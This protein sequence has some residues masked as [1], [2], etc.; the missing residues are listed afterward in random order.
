MPF[1]QR[2]YVLITLILLFSFCLPTQQ[3]KSVYNVLYKGKIIGQVNVEH[4]QQAE[5]LAINVTSD[6]AMKMLFT[7]KVQTKEQSVYNSDTLTFSSSFRSVNG[8]EKLNRQIKY[9]NNLYKTITE[10]KAGTMN[11]APINYNLLRLYIQEPVGITK[12]FSDNTQ[13]FV[14]VKLQSEHTY[15]LEMP[16]GNSNTYHYENGI[17]T[18]IDVESTWCDLQMQLVN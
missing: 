8:K 2:I 11:Q 9:Q 7:I 17:C 13:Q 18:K 6:I 4:M 1:F 12:V 15:S 14:P 10:G 5:S 16:N 3:N